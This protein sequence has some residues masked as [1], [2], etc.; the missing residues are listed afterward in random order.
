MQAQYFI[1]M[2]K[3][4]FAL[5]LAGSVGTLALLLYL[6]VVS[7]QGGYINTDMNYSS[8]SRVVD[9]HYI[10][11]ELIQMQT[12]ISKLQ[13][14]IEISNNHIYHPCKR[15]DF[16]K[17]KVTQQ[18][19]NDWCASAIDNH[20]KF[21][22]I[23]SLN[24]SENELLHW[25][26]DQEQRI[27][28]RIAAKVNEIKCYTPTQFQYPVPGKARQNVH[29][30]LQS[31]TEPSFVMSLPSELDDRM[32]AHHI[33]T[34][35]KWD[36]HIAMAIKHIVYDKCMQSDTA[37]I[38]LTIDVGANLGFETMVLSSY[39]CRVAAFEPNPLMTPHTLSS[40]AFNKFQCTR[41]YPYILSTE[42]FETTL[43][44]NWGNTQ[45]I[46]V[47][48]IKNGDKSY[49]G[50]SSCKNKRCV[51]VKTV[52]LDDVIHEDVLLMKMDVEGYEGNVLRTAKKLL[53]EHTVHNILMEYVPR[54]LKPLSEL[55]SSGV[56]ILHMFDDLG[57]E[58]RAIEFIVDHPDNELSPE[59]QFSN[60][61]LPDDFVQ[62]T[63]NVT[64]GLAEIRGLDMSDLWFKKVRKSLPT[65]AIRW[66]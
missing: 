35:G 24:Q 61:I 32:V 43:A 5:M 28:V 22:T 15:C 40:L 13:S 52:K 49:S 11:L 39:G 20:W 9:S 62:F 64:L 50:T 30:P 14:S 53:T 56:E 37:Y 12:A 41:L 47:N 38:P 55:E 59:P 18:S 51:S 60:V 10:H 25:S 46:S 54:V 65:E 26:S 58:V 57:Y 17:S 31:K 42:P 8:T 66:I 19:Q 27:N 7:N 21:L 29:M 3:Q 1:I 34:Q 2:T 48:E 6:F 4:K 33:L 63:L 23:R 44:L 45:T 16:G 36:T